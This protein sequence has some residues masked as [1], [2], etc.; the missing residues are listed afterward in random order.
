[1]LHTV[2]FSDSKRGVHM[3][4]KLIRSRFELETFSVLD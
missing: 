2:I 1:M 4:K 3:D